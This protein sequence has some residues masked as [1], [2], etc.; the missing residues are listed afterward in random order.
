MLMEGPAR[1]QMTSLNV[2]LATLRRKSLVCLFEL[3]RNSLLC[4]Q[5]PRNQLSLYYV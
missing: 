1:D 3:S 2:Y 5:V 4:F